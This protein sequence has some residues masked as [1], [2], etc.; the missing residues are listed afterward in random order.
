[1]QGNDEH[2]Q[3]NGEATIHRKGIFWAAR[4]RILL[5]YSLLLVLIF[6]A[7]IPAFRSMLM[8]RVDE[9]VRRDMTEKADTFTALLQGQINDSLEGSHWSERQ[10]QRLQPPDSVQELAE[11][12]DAYLSRQVPEDDVFLIT[13][14]EGKFYRSSP[15]ARPEVFKQNTALMNRWAKLSTSKQG[16]E[17][18]DDPEL[19]KLVYIAKPVQLQGQTIGVFVMAHT[20]AGEQMEVLEA[21]DVVV[22]VTGGVLVVALVLG[23]FASGQVLAPLRLLSSTARSISESD[24]TQRIP[25]R[26]KGEIADLA[27]TFNDM[28]DRLQSAFISQRNF[29][30]D[31]GHELRTPLTIIRGHLELMDN[32]PDEQQETLNIVMDELDRMNRFVDDLILLAKSERSDFLQLELVNIETLTHELF[33][34]ACALADRHWILD[35]VGRGQVVLDRQRITQAMMNLAQNATQ[36]TDATQTI[37]LGSAIRSGKLH[38]WV[39]DTGEGISLTDQN[40][41]FDRFARAANSRRRSEGAG[42][43]L[44]IVRAIV[45]AHHGQITLH[46]QLRKGSKFTIVIPLDLTSDRR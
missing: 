46:S 44:S 39:R 36:Y 30:N 13:F 37:A 41:I 38:L 31:A 43:G 10:D 6:V 40:R 32:D 9:R 25:L 15:R 11:F 4:N 33:A 45:E 12:F 35:P 5:Y 24:L 8:R 7:V 19:G 42:L 20:T 2:C 14:I 34:K 21:V 28:M 29:I 27:S 26:G 18:I 23:W 22:Q 16:E 1:M 3:E 17:S